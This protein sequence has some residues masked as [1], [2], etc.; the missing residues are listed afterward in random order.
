MKY[1]LLLELIPLIEEFE[2][3]NEFTN[4]NELL[5]FVT[6]INI[7]FEINNFE[8][9]DNLVDNERIEVTISRLIGFMGRY[10]KFYIKKALDGT[11]LQSMEEFTFLATLLQSGNMTKSE[12]INR[13]LMEKPTGMEIINRLISNGMIHQIESEVDKRSKNLN[14]SEFGKSSLFTVF[15]SINMVADLVVGELNKFE[16][17]HLAQCL[18]KLDN[19]HHTIFFNNKNDSIEELYNSKSSIKPL[20]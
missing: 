7:K 4:K 20:L 9:I 5:N 16:K 1:K 3:D 2:K 10:A 12:L 13:N 8:N 17:I 14:L 6:W 18:L 11:A 19:F 15:G